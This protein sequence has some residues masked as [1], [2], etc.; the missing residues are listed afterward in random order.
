MTDEH[1]R[2]LR[3]AQA[4]RRALLEHGY[5]D[6]VATERAN[7]LI[8]GVAYRVPA[9]DPPLLE[10]VIAVLRTIGEPHCPGPRLSLESLELA[11]CAVV[12]ALQNEGFR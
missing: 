10:D 2:K 12:A 11:A 4:A 3:G 7:N 9:E 1:T 8:D 6:D 5:P